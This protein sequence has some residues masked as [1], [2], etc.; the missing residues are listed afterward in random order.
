MYVCMY[1]CM[2]AQIYKYSLLSLLLCV[3]VLG[4]DHSVLT[5]VNGVHQ[6]E[7]LT[8]LLLAAIICCGSLIE[9]AFHKNISLPQ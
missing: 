5:A 4:T 8:L 2:Y 9:V 1:V 7:R 3:Y 6:R